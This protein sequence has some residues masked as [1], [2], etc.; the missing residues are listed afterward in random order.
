MK[1]FIKEKLQIAEDIQIASVSRMKSGDQPPV[2][3]KLVNVQD[4]KKILDSAGKLKGTKNAKEQFYGVYSHLND[5]D[6]EIDMRKRNII[7]MNKELPKPLRQNMLLSKGTLTVNG[8]NYQSKILNCSAKQLL[9]LEEEEILAAEEVWA[10]RSDEIYDRNSVFQG[11]GVAVNSMEEVNRVYQHFKLK[12]TDATHIMMAYRLPGNNKAYDEDYY[13]DGEYGGGH[14][15]WRLLMDNDQYSVMLL[16]TRY[17]GQQLLGTDRF[18][19]IKASALDALQKLQQ[20]HTSKSRLAL[21]I[22]KDDFK[23][24]QGSLR[25]PRGIKVTPRVLSNNSRHA[26]PSTQRQASHQPVPMAGAYNRFKLLAT[27]SQDSNYSEDE[28]EWRDSRNVWD[29]EYEDEQ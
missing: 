16:V 5:F 19:H 15:L 17:Y 10:S 14:R 13:D 26:L 8:S 23:E 3:V 12:F 1:D 11:F 2:L 27:Q 29:T 9:Q 28:T 22:H 25:P 24:L 4:R 20:K 6:T 7:K 21:Q 18:D